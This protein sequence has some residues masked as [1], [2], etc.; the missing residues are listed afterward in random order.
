ME[1]KF[2]KSYLVGHHQNIEKW[3]KEKSIEV[4]KKKRP[5]LIKNQNKEDFSN[6]A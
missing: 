5:D 6:K 3:R 2:Q 4:T 1:L